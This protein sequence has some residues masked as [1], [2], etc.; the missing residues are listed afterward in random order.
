MTLFDYVDE[1]NKTELL[2]GCLT[3]FPLL[4]RIGFV[5]LIKK[6]YLGS[7]TEKIT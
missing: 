1:N 3:D 5:L 4:K 7:G 2:L 6:S